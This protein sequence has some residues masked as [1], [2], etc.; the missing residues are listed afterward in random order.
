MKVLSLKY[1]FKIGTVIQQIQ[2]FT[3]LVRARSDPRARL[4]HVNLETKEAL[5]ELDKTY[6]APEVDESLKKTT[7]KA[8]KVK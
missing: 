1:Y 3:E 7:Q 5:A 6:K 4:N 2:K 8:D